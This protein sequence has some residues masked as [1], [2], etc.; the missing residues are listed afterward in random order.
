MQTFVA[1]F[2]RHTARRRAAARLLDLDDWL[3]NDIGLSRAD[4][5]A[6]LRYRG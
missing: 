6:Q 3:L 4:I 5:R 2:L 1:A